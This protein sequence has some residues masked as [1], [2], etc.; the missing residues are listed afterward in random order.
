MK[1]FKRDNDYCLY[2]ELGEIIAA[3]WA[4]ATGKKLSQSNCDEI[5]G[6]FDV[7]LLATEYY[8]KF[9]NLPVIRYNSFTSGYN[10]AMELK[11]DKLFTLEQMQKAFEF[12]KQVE[13]EDCNDNFQEYL[14]SIKQPTEIEVEIIKECPQCQEWGYVSECRN[15]CNQKFLQPKFD[16]EKCLILKKI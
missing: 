13:R 5:F 9:D 10:K 8:K 2:N 7:D 14:R 12:G 4:N 1:L 15:D 6:V 16:A 3:S 11:K